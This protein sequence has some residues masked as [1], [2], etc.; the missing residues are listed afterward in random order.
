MKRP[1]FDG[2]AKTLYSATD[3]AGISRWTYSLVAVLLVL[4]L[5]W[6][7]TA[8]LASAV[9]ISGS[10]KVYKNRLMLQHP[11]GGR[12]EA[13]H[14]QEGDA[15]RE[16]DVLLSLANPQLV[17]VVRGLER[18][19]FSE[20]LR[21][22]RLQAEMA[23]PNGRFDLGR[24]PQDSEYEIIA[25]TEFN[26]FQARLRNLISQ[27]QLLQQQV[28]F[29]RDEIDA[30]GRSM[31]NDKSILQQTLR[32]EQ[33]GFVSPVNVLNAEQTVNQRDAELARA[34]QRVAELE[35]RLPMLL[36]DYRNNAAMEYR[37]ASERLLDAE[38]KLRPSKDAL[39]NLLVRAPTE[40]TVVNLTRLGV[41]AVLGAKETVA[42]LVPA[43]RGLILEGSL[44]TEQVA[45]LQAGM[46]ARVRIPQLAK[47]GHDELQGSLATISADSVSQGMLG[48][49]AY[50]VQVD[51]GKLPPE[52]EALLRPG[53]PA[54]IFIQTGT[55]TPL[56]YLS[57][58]VT[59]FLG[60]AARE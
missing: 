33:Q 15:V 3:V 52:V 29:V 28:T 9:I 11:E 45:F 44:A 19:V 12:I 30:L 36:D 32:L 48:T 50:M 39:S 21:A 2:W 58:P 60:R 43:E 6:L 16:G 25:T 18:Q 31:T 34:K 17:S 35:Q 13:V 5:L 26:L 57:E 51:L 37:L 40:G 56:Q 27:E 55:R 41:G 47:I 23:Y 46:P 4:C 14:V 22:Q 8:P 24:V 54:E 42:E 38:E 53:M 49:A 7:A 1:S 59:S 20:S 10:V